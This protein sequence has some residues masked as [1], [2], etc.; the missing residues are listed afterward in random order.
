MLSSTLHQ[1]IQM[2]KKY[3]KPLLSLAAT[4]S[5]SALNMP[6]A[7]AGGWTFNIT[8]SGQS[9]IMRVEASEDGET[10]GAFTGSEIQPGDT[11]KMEWSSS[12]DG[13]NCVWQVRAV[14]EDA[15]SEPASFDFCKKPHIEFS[16]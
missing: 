8:N 16:N 9:T 13:S 11:E 10:W 14:Y 12:T 7:K 1:G 15:T 2:H 3:W 4:L 6:F 5:I